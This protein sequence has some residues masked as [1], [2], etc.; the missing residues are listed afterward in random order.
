MKIWTFAEVNQK[1]RADLDMQE[2]DFVTP[3]EMVGYVNEAIHEAE[4]EILKISEDYFLKS[5]PL[6]FVL[7]QD[8]YDLPADIYGQKIRGIIY[9]NG[10]IQYSIRRIRG[11]NKFDVLTMI[12]QYGI[13]DDYMYFLINATAGVQNKILIAPTSRDVG[14]FATM[15]YIRS[16]GRIQTAAEVGIDPTDPNTVGQLATKIDIPEFSTFI[17]DY[18][19]CKCL[20][21]D[22]DP[23]FPDQVTIME[24]QRK[25]M[26]DSLTGQVPDDDDTI[27]PDLSF[28]TQS[29]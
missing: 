29:S 19:K 3:D 18:T 9:S 11:M 5:A 25:M 1:V 27:Q 16:A 12:Q 23:R 22:T 8:L 7:G 2:E 24:S 13:N 20:S 6:T 10:S 17:I 14:P 21:K 4:S 15:W 28:Y 26:I